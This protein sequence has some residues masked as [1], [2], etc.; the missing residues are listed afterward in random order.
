MDRLNELTVQ[1]TVD[2]SAAPVLNQPF[3]IIVPDE[4]EETEE[5]EVVA[6]NPPT[7]ESELPTDGFLVETMW[8]AYNDLKQL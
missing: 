3:F 7:F 8:Q 4:E 1:I 5:E 2:V 6:N